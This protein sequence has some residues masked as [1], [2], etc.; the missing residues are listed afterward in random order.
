MSVLQQINQYLDTDV[1]QKLE[2]IDSKP[3]LLDE[4]VNIAF[5]QC[6]KKNEILI[7]TDENEIIIFHTAGVELFDKEI[8]LSDI[9]SIKYKFNERLKGQTI[10][11]PTRR[12][13]TF[14]MPD[15]LTELTEE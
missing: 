10:E 12:A 7:V 1:K 8:N 4:K 11:S 15:Q 13:L 2:W 6:M 3:L 14:V 9:N 5:C